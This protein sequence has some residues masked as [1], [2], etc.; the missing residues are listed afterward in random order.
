[1]LMYDETKSRYLILLC[2][3]QQQVSLKADNLAVAGMIDQGRAYYEMIRYS[4]DI[5]RQWQSMVSNIQRNTGM[6]IK[7]LGISV[8]VVIVVLL[9]VLG[10][11]KTM[12]VLSMV[13]LL[14]MIFAPDILSPNA[15]MTTIVQNAPMRWKAFLRENIPSVGNVI[16]D[17]NLYLSAFTV[18]SAVLLLFP[19]F[20]TS[21]S[22]AVPITSS[23]DDASHYYK[24]GYDD[25]KANLDFGASLDGATISQPRTLVDDEEWLPPVSKSPFTISNAMAVFAIVRTVYPLGNNGGG[26]WNWRLAMTN[27]QTLPKWQMGLLA[28]SVYR[29]VAAFV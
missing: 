24:L 5:Q 20:T 13:L 29:L 12:L 2:V 17:N 8:A 7:S 14:S 21:A 23:S 22:K 6:S 25:A 3:S 1:M 19:L 18:L 16:A 28:L 15:T 9:Y 4:P 10:I 26:A 27:L 11:T